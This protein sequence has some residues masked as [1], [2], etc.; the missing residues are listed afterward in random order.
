VLSVAIPTCARC[1][2][3]FSHGCN[4][5]YCSLRCESRHEMTVRTDCCGRLVLWHRAIQNDTMDDLLHYC[6]SGQGCQR[7][8]AREREERWPLG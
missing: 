5:G 1:R 8:H 2:Q 6:L 4:S 7:K 3:P